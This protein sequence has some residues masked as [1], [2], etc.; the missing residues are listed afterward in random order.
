MSSVFSFN[1]SVAPSPPVDAG[2][3]DFHKLILDVRDHDGESKI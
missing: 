2:D 3:E 1:S